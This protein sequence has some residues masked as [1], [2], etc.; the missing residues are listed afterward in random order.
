[1]GVVKADYDPTQH[2]DSN[3]EKKYSHRPLLGL[4]LLS[5]VAVVILG[6]LFW[7]YLSCLFQ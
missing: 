1:V 3:P 4:I 6:W 7:P 2:K 5:W